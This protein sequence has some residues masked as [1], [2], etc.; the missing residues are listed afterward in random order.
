MGR[1]VEC[2]QGKPPTRIDDGGVES[3]IGCVA[4]S[5]T[6]QRLRQLSPQAFCLKE[7]PFVKGWAVS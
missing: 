6:F 1:F 2:I 4:P 7:L 3:G 5:K